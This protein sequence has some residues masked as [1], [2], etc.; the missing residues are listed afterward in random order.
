MDTRRLLDKEWA[1]SL[2][3]SQAELKAELKDEEWFKRLVKVQAEEQAQL[4][5]EALAETLVKVQADMNEEW[6]ES[7]AKVQAELK[8][9]EW[10]EWPVEPP[11]K[12]RT[13]LLAELLVK[14]QW[15][16]SRAVW[17]G[18]E[19]ISA[20]FKEL[21]GSKATQSPSEAEELRL[22]AARIVSK[23]PRCW[24][25]FGFFLPRQR[26]K[27]IF[28]N[29]IA[30]HTT[31]LFEALNG[32]GSRREQNRLICRFMIEV[33]AMVIECTG[34]AFHRRL[35]DEFDWVARRLPRK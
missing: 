33:V 25:R 27:D 21:A 22:R 29:F 11:V 35:Y 26:R 16:D 12:K 5:D 17:V 20:L 8:D 15:A 9:E 4:K 32:A 19:Q 6:A 2:V 14:F 18:W 28:E 3:E 7:L 30:D 13:E 10:A 24:S 1:E 34:F 23:A 31:N